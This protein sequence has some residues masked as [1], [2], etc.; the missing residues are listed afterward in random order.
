[1]RE[2]KQL[3]LGVKDVVDYLD[4]EE[5]ELD[6]EL[7]TEP[8]KVNM[9]PSHPATHGTVRIVLTVEG[10]TVKEGDVQVGYLHRCFEKESEHATWTQVF[11]YTD[12]LNYVSP[13]LNNVG[14]ALAVEKLIG[15]VDRIPERAQYIRVIVGELSRITD[16]LTCCAAGAMELGAM[17][18]FFW[19]IKGR[20]WIWELL[21]EISGAR[22]THSYVRIGG[23]AY[24]IPPGWIEKV[25]ALF[26]KLEGILKDLE[27]ATL[28][29]KIFRDRMDGTGTITQE[30]ALS[31]GWTGPCLRSTGI[32]YDVRVA[33]PYLVYDRFDF[34]VPVGAK[35]D[36]FDRYIVRLQEI[37]QSMSIIKQA[38]AQLPGGPVVLDDPRIVLP[39]KQEVYNTIEGMISHFKLI[40]DGI[41]V[42]AGEVYS[43]TEGG[44]G[45]LG[46]Y[47]VSDGTGRPYK[48][49]VRPPCFCIVSALPEMIKDRPLADIIPT[50][51]MMNMI[52]GE[53]D[54]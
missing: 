45:E 54:R 12:R 9:G 41:K 26:P 8:M 13:M 36:N 28:E 20:E 49:R 52:G 39:P 25:T 5:H 6:D 3:V 32:P 48:C 43:Y 17:T 51:D 40:V 50:F 4:E 34:E 7:P 22:L 1:M 30:Q 35:G 18:I 31:Y 23:V 14:Y 44:N 15:V 2:R 11:P 27:A 19:A 46:F 42:P 29:N 47:L 38:F 37:R 21:E 53:C 24:D 16:H 10:E 33:H